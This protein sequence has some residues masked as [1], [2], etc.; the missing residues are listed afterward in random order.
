MHPSTQ[1]QPYRILWVKV[2]P[3]LPANSGGR[4][5]SL[6]M[7]REISRAGH[8]VHYLSLGSAE[9]ETDQEEQN[10]S[11]A[12]VKEWVP[13]TPSKKP[14]GFFVAL[15]RNLTLSRR[16]Y[17][18]DKYQSRAWEER[19]SHQADA[20]DFIICDFL[21][22]AI[23]FQ[24]LKTR[25]PTLLFQHNI[26]S[27]IWKRLADSARNPL[28]S[29][30]LRSQQRRMWQAEKT[31]SSGF[32]GIITVSPKDTAFCT[33]HYGLTNVLGDVPTGV[34]VNAFAQAKEPPL[35]PTIGFLGSMDWMPNIEGVH[36]FVQEVLPLLRQ[37]FPTLRLKVIGRN[38][39]ASLRALSQADSAIEITGTVQEV[40]PHV[41]E[42]SV[43]AVPL[44]AGG[45][46]R[47]KIF[48]AM[49]MGVPVVSTTIGAE[50]LP[51]QQGQ[52]LLIADQPET[53]AQAI[54][55]LLTDPSKAVK[56]AT[57]AR[58]RMVNEFSWRASAEHFI[59][60]CEKAANGQ[61]NQDRGMKQPVGV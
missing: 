50:G 56:L 59:G 58:E 51:L 22:P 12:A 41:H 18:L 46:T 17:V 43:I 34:D 16:P 24:N 45:G 36:W 49:A 14:I 31:L 25:T 47:I 48:E 28:K 42:C 30:Y 13:W 54:L 57:N 55:S 61:R 19:I 26:E 35:I 20:F 4:L 15:L 53:F 11:Y 39:P 52:D 40:Q 38:P 23:H 9:S 2:G 6:A 3:L 8:H 32:D 21:T 33:E 29:A 44:L 60:L 1:S 7:L 10:D 5:R 27:Q 37:H